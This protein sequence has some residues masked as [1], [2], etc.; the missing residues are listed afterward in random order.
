[1]QKE[2]AICGTEDQNATSIAT[3][4]TCWA[5]T[6]AAVGTE[7]EEEEEDDDDDD[8]DDGAGTTIV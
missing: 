3:N 5:C 4:L 6:P 1:M 8:D 7:E 2:H